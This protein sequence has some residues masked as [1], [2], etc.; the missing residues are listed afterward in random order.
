MTRFIYVCVFIHILILVYGGYYTYAKPLV[1]GP[2][3]A[4]GWS[5]N[6]YDRSSLRARLLPVFT[7]REG[8]VAQDEARAQTAG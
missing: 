1:S 2:K 5:R 7:V 4:F 6:N 3:Q 8:A